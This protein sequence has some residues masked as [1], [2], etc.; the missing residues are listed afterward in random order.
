MTYSIPSKIFTLDRDYNGL[1]D[2]LY[3]GDMGGQIW[4]IG[5]FGTPFPDSDSNIH[6][7]E[8]HKIFTARCNETDCTDEVDNDGDTLIDDA[9]TSKFFYPPTV[10]IEHNN[11]LVFIGSGDRDDACNTDTQDALYAIKD[12]HGTLSFVLDDL[13]NADTTATDY[14]VPDLA[15][16]HNGW[17]LLMEPGEKALAESVVF[18][19]VL[20]A[21]SFLPNNEACVPGGYARLYALN[22][23]TGAPAFDFDGDDDKDT[24]KIIGGGIPSKP[25]VIITTEGVAKLL[26]STSSTNP[27]VD[28]DITSAG[29]TTTGLEFPD[30]NFFLRWWKEVFD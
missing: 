25:V 8:V 7:W 17:Y 13:Q 12:N 27:D 10:T 29:V 5:N 21:T 28:S 11:D 9:D 30:I 6:N 23:L 24:A 14:V 20:Y 18:K 4:R 3:V 16:A 19:K 26:I 1:T 15:G 2:K 22:Y